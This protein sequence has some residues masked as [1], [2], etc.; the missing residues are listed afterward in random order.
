MN[1]PLVVRSN[2]GTWGFDAFSYGLI[3]VVKPSESHRMGLLAHEATHAKQFI[4]YGIVGFLV[5]YFCSSR[6]RYKFELEAYRV[7]CSFPE[8][9]TESAAWSLATKYNINHTYE[10]CLASI[11]GVQ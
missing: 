1:F 2:Y 4:K 8:E 6:W 3:T 10:E 7:Q 11:V 9:S 5:L